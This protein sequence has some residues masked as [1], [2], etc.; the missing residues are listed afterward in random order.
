MHTG[1]EEKVVIYIIL[2]FLYFNYA[3]YTYFYIKAKMIFS[4][5]Y[6][7]SNLV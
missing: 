6:M 2:A 4:L 3:E 1:K 7:H 5:Y